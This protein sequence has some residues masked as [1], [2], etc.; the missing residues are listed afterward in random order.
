MVGVPSGSPDLKKG[1]L[2][3][4]M[5]CQIDYKAERGKLR[6]WL[7]FTTPM[8]ISAMTAMDWLLNGW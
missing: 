4:G 1:N 2:F 8:V 5:I 6:R 3:R 7:H